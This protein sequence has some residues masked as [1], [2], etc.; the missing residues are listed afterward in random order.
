M[1][2]LLC[3]FACLLP[4]ASAADSAGLS[5]AVMFALDLLAACSCCVCFALPALLALNQT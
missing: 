2:R 3:F 5:P 4:A 1:L